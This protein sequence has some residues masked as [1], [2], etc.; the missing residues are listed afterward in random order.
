M[1]DEN[2]SLKR[3]LTREL[4]Q[5]DNYKK[6][7]SERFREIYNEIVNASKTKQQTNIVKEVLNKKLQSR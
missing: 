4:L 7:V 3:K 6:R 1:T 2:M 5:S